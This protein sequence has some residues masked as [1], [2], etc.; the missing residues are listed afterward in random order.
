M[1]VDILLSD[2]DILFG[3]DDVV[4]IKSRYSMYFIFNRANQTNIIDAEPHTT[5]LVHSF[6]DT[7]RT[8]SPKQ[9]RIKLLLTTSQLLCGHLPPKNINQ[10][11]SQSAC[12]S[13]IIHLTT[14]NPAPPQQRAHLATER[15]GRSSGIPAAIT[16]YKVVQ[17]TPIHST[18]DK[19]WQITL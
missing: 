17:M 1:W 9:F 13:H 14:T 2:N 7:T 19:S 11:A 16:W 4:K 15:T 5:R 8:H 18:V 12:T 6:L 3:C 10:S